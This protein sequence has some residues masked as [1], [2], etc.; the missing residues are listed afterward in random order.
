MPL[1]HSLELFPPGIISSPV[2]QPDGHLGKARQQGD[3]AAFA[4]GKQRH[5]RV[6][7]LSV[8]MLHD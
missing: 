3:Q 2:E 1:A 4:Q 7:T 5:Q 8:R 6:F